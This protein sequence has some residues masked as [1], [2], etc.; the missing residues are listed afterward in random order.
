MS[1]Q[2]FFQDK[3][4]R[5]WEQSLTQSGEAVIPQPAGAVFGQMLASALGMTLGYLAVVLVLDQGW[6][7]VVIFGVI[8]LALMLTIAAIIVSRPFHLHISWQGLQL[9]HL[10]FIPWSDVREVKQALGR[11]QLELNP[12]QGEWLVKQASGTDRMRFRYI[13]L[14]GRGSTFKLPSMLRGKPAVQTA[15]LS[16]VHQR[17]M[18]HGY[19]NFQHPGYQQ[20]QQH[21]GGQQQQLY[22]PQG[23]HSQY[24]PHG[25]PQYGA[26]Q[27]H[28]PQYG[29]HGD[30]QQPQGQPPYP[31]QH[32]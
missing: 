32:Y 28:S 23:S 20:H 14:R 8:A 16:S 22:G 15:W 10:P 29:Q 24:N 6:L 5:T 7:R 25:Q 18:H 4:A 27:P 2:D 12:G 1:Q 9:G 21:S 17:I 19:G 31:Q 3:H 13:A 11:P 26:P 30:G